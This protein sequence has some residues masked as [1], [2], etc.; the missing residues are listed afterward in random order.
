MVERHAVMALAEPGRVRRC[1]EELFEA[2]EESLV[3]RQDLVE[4]M[5]GFVVRAGCVQP[6]GEI[7]YGLSR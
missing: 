2:V 7:T 1:F 6:A 5:G 3:R 4:E